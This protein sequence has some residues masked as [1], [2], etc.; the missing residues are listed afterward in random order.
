MDLW[1]LRDV[2]NFLPYID[3]DVP[4]IRA[5]CCDLLEFSTTSRECVS[6]RL[7]LSASAL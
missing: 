3:T 1:Q 2:D 7:S 5:V 4:D 6:V